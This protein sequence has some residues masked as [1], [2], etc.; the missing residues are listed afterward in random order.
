M[1]YIKDVRI[2]LCELIGIDYYNVRFTDNSIYSTYTWNFIQQ[3]LFK[4]WFIDYLK[5]N[6]DACRFFIG[7]EVRSKALLTDYVESY[8]KTQC[9]R[10]N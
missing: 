1:Q 7:G 5:T 6:K 2:K 10:S 9:W 3:G 8:M 4:E